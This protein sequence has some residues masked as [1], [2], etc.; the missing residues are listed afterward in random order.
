MEYLN[1]LDSQQKEVV[2]FSGNDS[3]VLAGAGSG[4]TRCLQYRVAYLLDTQPRLH[5]RSVVAISF[6]K[7]ASE[8]L[9]E[10]ISQ[11]HDRGCQIICR[12]MHSFCYMLIRKAGYARDL[13]STYDLNK[14]VYKILKDLKIKTEEPS[15][16]FIG[17]AN[18]VKSKPI[19]PSERAKYLADECNIPWM[20]DFITRYEEEKSKKGLMD[21]SDMI[22][23]AWLAFKRNPD[24]LASVQNQFKY[25]IVDEAQDLNAIQ[26]ELALM[27]SEKHRGLMLC[28]DVRQSIYGFR[29]ADPSRLIDIVN[30]RDM[31]T[32]N[33]QRNYRSAD[34]IVDVANKLIAFN[35]IEGTL[36]PSISMRKDHGQINCEMFFTQYDEAVSV[37]SKCAALIDS[38]VPAHEIAVLYRVNSQSQWIQ[39][40]FKEAGIPF[41]VT[42]GCGFFDR[43]EIQDAIAFLQLA[44][45]ET[46]IDALRRIYNKPTRYLGRAFLDTL[47]DLHRAGQSVK[48]TLQDVAESSYRN[49]HNVD[50]L[51]DIVCDLN[52][53]AKS[54]KTAKELLLYIYN[55]RSKTDISKT[56]KNLNVSDDSSD[57]VRGENLDSLVELA[58]TCETLESFLRIVSDHVTSSDE[59]QDDRENKVQFLTVHRSK[60]LEFKDVFV[61][62]FAEGVFPHFMGCIQE[63][64]RVA[65]VALTRAKDNLH[66]SVPCEVNGRPTGDSSFLGEIGFNSTFKE[67]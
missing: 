66:I 21:F 31:A 34:Q 16:Y 10:R 45:D 30:A 11:T 28:G 56:F 65:Y 9:L 3:I 53:M 41:H 23:F 17:L 63:E 37:A 2:T 39:V 67:A 1:K 18:D 32:L 40:A 43:A 47:N 38:G 64:R 35:E 42:G 24:F 12:T 25:F 33:L 14:I 51:L 13:A 7:K 20:L 62:G 36:P 44:H 50:D 8:E 61:I 29:G 26:L 55:L 52:S 19:L 49:R 54:G 59:D 57:D 15:S 4:K 58:E 27:I 22:Y 6:T 46:N 5:P 60:G 48:T